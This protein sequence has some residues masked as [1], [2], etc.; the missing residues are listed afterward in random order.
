[1]KTTLIAIVLAAGVFA[2]EKGQTRIISEDI[3]HEGTPGTRIEARKFVFSNGQGV[4]MISGVNVG[5][6]VTKAPYAAEAVTEFVQTLYDGNRI[7]Q[8][9]STKQFRDSEG[10]ER[11]EEG[12]MNVVFITDPVAKVSYTL[13]PETKSAEKIAGARATN[14]LVNVSASTFHMSMVPPDQPFNVSVAGVRV[15]APK[16]KDED[17]GT[18]IIEGVEA[19]GTRTVSTIPAGEIGND[20]PIEIVDERW[21][22]PELQLTVLTR[23]I[24]PRS[25]ENTYKLIN[26]QRIEQVRSLFEIPQGYTVHEA[27]K[28]GKVVGE[29][30]IEEE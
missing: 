5:P 18:R 16:A 1:M 19:K 9:S 3:V 24:D 10:R 17:L 29:F 4:E 15:S 7:V 22:S 27:P 13:H 8:R 23:H 28:F 25:G 6:T 11:R 21:Y 20:R 14:V 2:Q 12:Q 30:K 26:I